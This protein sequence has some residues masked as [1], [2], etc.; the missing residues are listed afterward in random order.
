MAVHH[1]RIVKRTGDGSIIEF[2]SV[3]DA[4]NCAIEIQRAM[5]E[6]NAEVAPNKRI[7]F[8]IGIHLGDV[9]EESDGDLI[10]DGVNIAARLEGVATGCDLSVRAC[11]LASQGTA[12]IQGRRSRPTE[13]QERRRARAR[14]P[15]PPRPAHDAESAR[16]H[17]EAARHLQALACARRRASLSPLVEAGACRGMRGWS[18][19]GSAPPW[20]REAR[21]RPGSSIGVLPVRRYS[22][23]EEQD[24]FADGITADLTTD[25]WHLPDSFVCHAGPRSPTRARRSTR[26]RSVANSAFAT[27][28]KAACGGSAR[29]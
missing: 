24:Y 19:A 20:P 9:V 13:A 27:C 10:G 26:K 12:R 11:L 29:R 23:D 8:R 6:R 18:L 25:L 17:D 14:L 3:V 4:V 1:G 15:A 28:W 16:S 21:T 7:E 5:V 2:R 22:G